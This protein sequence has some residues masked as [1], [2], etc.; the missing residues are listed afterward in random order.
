MKKARGKIWPKRGERRNNTKKLETI[1]KTNLD[2]CFNLCAV[3]IH[4]NGRGVRQILKSG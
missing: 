4:I 1:R 2:F 3:E